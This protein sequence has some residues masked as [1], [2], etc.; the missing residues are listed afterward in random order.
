M[1]SADPEIGVDEVATQLVDNARPIPGRCPKGC[2]AGL[3]DAGATVDAVVE[4]R[5][6][7]P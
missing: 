6:R 4:D 1:R 2:G 5:A 7:R 3:M